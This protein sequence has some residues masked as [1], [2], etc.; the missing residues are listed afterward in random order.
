[1]KFLTRT[2]KHSSSNPGRT[3]YIQQVNMNAPY[4]IERDHVSLTVAWNVP[5]NVKVE[6]FELE[7]L[8]K[9]EDATWVSL[10][11]SL[12]GNSIRKKN[13]LEGI[14]YSFRVRVRS[15]G[16]SDWSA[17]SSPS[18]DM[19]VLA[20]SAQIMDPPELVSRDDV[21]V[22]L[23][24]KEVPGAGG[25]ILRLRSDED[26][27]KGKEQCWSQVATTIKN[28]TVRKKGLEAGKT[29]HFAILPVDFAE[30]DDRV[31]SFSGSSAGCKVVT[32]PPFMQKLFPTTLI[33]RAQA[34]VAASSL[35]SGKV[36]AIY[37]SAHWCGP[38]RQFTPKLLELYAQCKA[39]NKRFEIVFCSADH[40]EEE[41]QQYHAS[42]TWPAIGYDEEHREGMMGMFKVSGIPRLTV[43][44]ANGRVLVENAI[45]GGAL[46]TSTVD[47][48][49]Q[50]SD[51]AK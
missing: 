35:L 32:M 49:I 30:D 50:M 37:F 22:T 29:Y 34:P 40:S 31:W 27:G 39:Q 24:W 12:K 1:M 21:S 15:A 8:T 3:H 23:E 46:S 25:Y 19:S 5:N 13:L 38:C 36:V 16:D 28:T 41:F 33:T 10:S 42:M 45:S 26:T 48:W 11:N 43:L 47:Q 6:A 7:M 14:K 4:L 9:Q 20:A 51:A 2:S 18:E 44:S 17:F